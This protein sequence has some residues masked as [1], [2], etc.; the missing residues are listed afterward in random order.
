MTALFLSLLMS[1]DNIARTSAKV[2]PWVEKVNPDLAEDP[3]EC[4]PDY[5]TP[6]P[7]NGCIMADLQCGSI[8]EG[9]TVTGGKNWG[10]EFYAN[11]FCSVERHQY[12]EAPEAIYR[13][14]VP[15]N[16]RATIKLI[17]NCAELDLA[18]V[19]WP[20][21]RCPTEQHMIH[22]CEMDVSRGGGSVVV[23]T[24]DNPQYFLV[25]VDGKNGE[26][27][28]FRLEVSCHTYR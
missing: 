13:L 18:A 1:C 5:N 12:H 19:G 3:V 26:T 21:D 11:H 15:P 6:T 16:L 27:G 9:S 2:F 25:G 4:S 7:R 28:N 22:E 24:V 8:V 23:Q 20:E 17:S 14:H 10:D